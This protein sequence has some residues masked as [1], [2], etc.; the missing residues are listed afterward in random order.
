MLKENKIDNLLFS[1]AL[2][3]GCGD[4]LA[5]SKIKL[6]LELNGVQEDLINKFF[7]Q[8]ALNFFSKWKDIE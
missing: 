4:A 7:Y 5:L 3:W 1:S 6:G 2:A 8:N